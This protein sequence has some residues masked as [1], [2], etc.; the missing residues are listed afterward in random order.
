MVRFIGR[1]GD[2]EQLPR[3]QGHGPLVKGRLARGRGLRHRIFRN[4]GPGWLESA[5]IG[6]TRKLNGAVFIR[7]APSGVEPVLILHVPRRCGGRSRG[8]S[9]I[10]VFGRGWNYQTYFLLCPPSCDYTYISGPDPDLLNGGIIVIE[11]STK[12]MLI[13]ER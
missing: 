5:R 4:A 13:T 8:L 2:L 1:G 7:P 12:V 3:G 11:I 6:P 9:G 10:K